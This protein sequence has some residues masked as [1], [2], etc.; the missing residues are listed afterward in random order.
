MLGPESATELAE[1]LKV[2]GQAQALTRQLITFAKGGTLRKTAVDLHDLVTDAV[3]FALRGS[4]ISTEFSIARDLA[5]VEADPSQIQQVISS[6]VVNARQALAGS[7]RLKVSACNR[8][9][10]SPDPIAAIGYLVETTAS[11]ED[12]EAV[13]RQALEAGDPF[14]AVVMDLTVPGGRGGGE[15]IEVLRALSPEVAAIAMSGYAEVESDNELTRRGFSAVLA[16][17][18][19]CEALTAVLESLAKR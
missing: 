18:F 14:H 16:K 13:F 9:L 5:P 1:A 19:K 17:P 10:E 6:L 4:P 11:G 15:T 8:R 12:C 7:G 3:G 2:I